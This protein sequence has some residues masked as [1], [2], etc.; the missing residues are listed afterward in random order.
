MKTIVTLD[1]ANQPYGFPQLDGNGNLRVGLFSSI[2]FVTSSRDFL[3]TDANKLLAINS[4]SSLTMPA[5]YPF[6]DGDIIGIYA[7]ESGSS[8]QNASGGYYIS[9]YALDSNHQNELVVLSAIAIASSLAPISTAFID[10]VG[11]ART[12]LNY[13][14]NTLSRYTV[15]TA[16]L[17]QTGTNAPTATILENT[18]GNITFT[19]D[20]TGSYNISGSFPSGKTTCI[21]SNIGQVLSDD[22]S[23]R[24]N[25]IADNIYIST[26]SVNFAGTNNY[27]DD[28]LQDTP[29]EIRVYN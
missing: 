22:I 3:S 16:L 9:P 26:T 12:A 1:K 25:I 7:I 13:T 20:D 14:M 19:Y 10:D 17:T 23:V 6:N 29:I 2:E 24:A 8:F 15:Y 5:V 21:I 28:I 27:S 18:I 4:G 11:F